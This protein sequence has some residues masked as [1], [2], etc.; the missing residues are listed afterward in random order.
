MICDHI[1]P[2]LE[3]WTEI[4][5][6]FWISRFCRGHQPRECA[7]REENMQTVEREPTQEGQRDPLLTPGQNAGKFTEWCWLVTVETTTHHN[8]TK[9]RYTLT[10]ATTDIET[11]Y[12]HQDKMEVNSQLVWSMYGGDWKIIGY[13]SVSKSAGNSVCV[14]V[15]N[16]TELCVN[17]K[18]IAMGLVDK[19][20]QFT[21][22][23]ILYK[24]GCTRLGNSLYCSWWIL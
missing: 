1:C 8:K 21:C 3:L 11:P 9:F 7:E 12:S 20:H 23:T 10:D 24:V 16:T 2:F 4:R 17:I 13:T 15:C 19:N 18:V 22:K 6:G 5:V 14:C